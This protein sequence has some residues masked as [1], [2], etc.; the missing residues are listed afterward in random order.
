MSEILEQMIRV[1]G[2]G[3]GLYREACAR[4][5]EA[6]AAWRDEKANSFPDDAARNRGSAAQLRALAQ[7]VRSFADG[8]FTRVDNWVR[9]SECPMID[10]G[11]RMFVTADAAW[12]SSQLGFDRPLAPDHYSSAVVAFIELAVAT[13]RAEWFMMRFA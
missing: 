12:F 7:F 2:D 13:A 8:P 9:F 4:H 3:P 5:F 6:Q 11:G 1:H 10:D